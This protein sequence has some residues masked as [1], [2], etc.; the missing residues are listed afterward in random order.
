ME[1][2]RR[3]GDSDEE[4]EHE[5]RRPSRPHDGD[6]D[7]AMDMHAMIEEAFLEIDEAPTQHPTLEER[8][9]DIVMGT[10]TVV[11]ELANDEDPPS[12]DESEGKPMRENDD[13]IG[14]DDYYG[15]PH[16]LEE[17]IDRAIP[18]SKIFNFG[19]DD[20]DNDRILFGRNSARLHPKKIVWLKNGQKS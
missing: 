6:I 13:G 4:W 8:V 16:E 15:D 12:D 11:D 5:F 2:A 1:G 18:W 14:E 19:G 7:E 3:E 10:F 20:I 9:E 17:A